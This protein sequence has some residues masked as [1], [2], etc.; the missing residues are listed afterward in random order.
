MDY[1]QQQKD[2]DRGNFICREITLMSLFI[3]SLSWCYA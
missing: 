1:N 2:D 3:L